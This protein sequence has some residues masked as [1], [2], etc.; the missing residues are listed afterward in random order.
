L[1]IEN[2]RKYIIKFPLKKI[3]VEGITN[4]NPPFKFGCTENASKDEVFIRKLA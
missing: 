1:T 4:S 2:K 3:R